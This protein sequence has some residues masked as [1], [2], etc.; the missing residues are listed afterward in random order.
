[1]Q[2]KPNPYH[3]PDWNDAALFLSLDQSWAGHGENVRFEMYPLNKHGSPVLLP[4]EAWEGGDGRMPRPVHQDAFKATVIRNLETAQYM[5]WYHTESRQM[6]P[7]VDP[8]LGQAAV[9]TVAGGGSRVCLALSNDGLRWQK[10]HL[11][12]TPFH[13]SLQNNMIPVARP[14]LLADHLSGVFP[15]RHAGAE[16]PL[17]ATFFSRY[18]DPIYPSGITQAE[19]DTGLEWRVYFPPT[20]PLDGDAHCVMWDANQQCYLCTT[21]SA[22]H[23]RIAARMA[24]RNVGGLTN[25]RHVAIARSR[26]LKNWTP[27]LDVLETDEQDPSNAEIYYMYIVPYGNLYIGFIQVFYVGELMSGGPLEMQIAISHNL[28]DWTRAGGRE[29]FIRLGN[30]GE[31][32]SRHV[33]LTTNPPFEEGNNLRFWYTGKNTDHWQAGDAA[34]GTGTIRRDGFACWNAP[35]EGILTTNP[36]SIRWA[37]WAELN[38]DASN[39]EVRME[40]TDEQGKPL[41][42]LTKDDCLPI[43]GDQMRATVSFAHPRGNFIRHT[44]PVRFRFH[45]KNARLYAFRAPNVHLIG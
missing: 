29:P 32:D 34:L 27:F 18:N 9:Q 30:E 21:R 25:K 14:P 23:T 1:M 35:E 44:G 13:G 15:L 24:A 26:D 43:T 28:V 11:G 17:G 6:G 31:W 5:L 38:V 33:S 36:L 12:L 16:S 40:I 8:A 42:G 2:M 3:H 41:P 37:S 20:L 7:F 19:S 45:L 39:G 10:P 4:S 22:Q